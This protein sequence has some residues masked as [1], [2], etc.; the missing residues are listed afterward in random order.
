[1]PKSTSWIRHKDAVNVD[2]EAVL[3]GLA[4][5]SCLSGR[6]TTTG[7]PSDNCQNPNNTSPLTTDSLRGRNAT[8]N[9]QFGL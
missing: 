2:L 5:K 7:T 6:I 3:R 4:H 8:S 9:V 1:M